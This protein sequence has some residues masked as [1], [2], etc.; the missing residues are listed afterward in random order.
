MLRRKES[1][2]GV[3]GRPS[4]LSCEDK[5]STRLKIVILS[6]SMTPRVQLYPRRFNRQHCIYYLSSSIHSFILIS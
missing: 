1:C 2:D 4:S 3:S 6:K 5:W